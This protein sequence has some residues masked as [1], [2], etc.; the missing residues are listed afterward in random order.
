M[1][2][3]ND[4]GE[5]HDQQVSQDHGRS[6]CSA[7]GRGGRG[8]R[9]RSNIRWGIWGITQLQCGTLQ[10]ATQTSCHCGMSPDTIG[11]LWILLWKMP[12]SSTGTMDSN[13]SSPPRVRAYT[14]GSTQ[15][16]QQNII[17]VG[18]L[19]IQFPPEMDE[20]WWRYGGELVT[21]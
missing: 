19:L 21:K 20:N 4:Q 8:G 12:S 1:S 17:R 15:W 3:F 9:G 14:N 18:Y 16:I 10:A 13:T 5:L 7:M 6:G 2:F 11:V